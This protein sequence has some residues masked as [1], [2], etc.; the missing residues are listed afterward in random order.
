MDLHVHTDRSTDALTPAR[1]VAKI[2]ARKGLSAIA[3]TD[4]DTLAGALEAIEHPAGIV[5]VPGVEIVVPGVEIS[6]PRGHVVALGIT[7]LP[8]ARDDIHE[9][10]DE[11]RG[12]GGILVAAHPF[13]A[14]SPFKGLEEVIDA[15]DAIE[16]ANASVLNFSSHMR[17]AGELLGRVPR[18]GLSAGSDSHMPETLGDVRLVCDSEPESVDDV[19]EAVLRRRCEAVGRRTSLLL[20]AKKVLLTGLGGLRGRPRP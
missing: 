9:L 4:H 1:Y 17:R 6:T 12:M 3:V 14:F 15:F 20:R 13:D 2:A 16:Y 10:S 18:L 7:S 11:V 5:V 8:R 19:I